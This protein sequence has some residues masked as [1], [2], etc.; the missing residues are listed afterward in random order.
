MQ[1][2]SNNGS[3]R[4]L[5]FGQ[6]KDARS[7]VFNNTPQTESISLAAFPQMPIMPPP[8]ST[9]NFLQTAPAPLANRHQ[10]SLFDKYFTSH[11]PLSHCDP[12]DITVLHK[13]VVMHEEELSPYRCTDL[14]P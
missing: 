13:N 8:T 14:G 3:G 4:P 5:L 10:A 7:F 9:P 11:L 6:H 1:N 2:K 12:R